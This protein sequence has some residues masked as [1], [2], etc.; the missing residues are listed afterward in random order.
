M[1]K[2]IYF[3]AT[4]LL[5]GLFFIQCEK[6]GEEPETKPAP[7]QISSSVQNVSEY[8]GSDG[9]IDLTVTGGVPPYSFLW[10]DNSTTEDVSNLVAGKYYVLVNDKEFQIRTDTFE[11][12]QPAPLPLSLQF[13]ITNPSETGAADGMINTIISGASPFTILWSTGADTKDISGL[14][15]GE[16]IITVTDNAG[17]T[18]TDTIVLEDALMDIDGNKYKTVKIGD[19]IWM[20]ENLKVT[21]APDG[22]EIESFIYNNDASYLKVYGR[23]YSWN[24]AMNGST[25]ES[26]QGICPN[27]WHIPTDNEVKVLEM[28]LGMTQAEADMVNTWRGKTVGTQLKAGGTSGFDAQLSGRRSNTGSYSFMGRVEYFWTS[29]ESSSTY[30]WRRCLDKYDDKS[31]R[32]NTFPKTYGFSIRCIKNDD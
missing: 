22:T 7:I 25:T 29:T 15:S 14:T 21:H 11:I 2:Q 23:L 20:K 27:G 8:G 16:Y 3:F 1:S 24:S 31:G 9:A 17:Q 5:A 26:T 6:E 12:T 30:A 32:Y 10:S 19:Q 4:C 13:E 18:A 28:A